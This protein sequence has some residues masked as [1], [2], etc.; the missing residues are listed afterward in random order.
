MVAPAEKVREDYEIVKGIVTAN[1]G[2][3][4]RVR[5]EDGRTAIFTVKG[6]ASAIG[7]GTDVGVVAHR[8]TEKAVF[9]VDRASGQRFNTSMWHNHEAKSPSP[10]HGF[11]RIF[12]MLMLL[13][14]ILGQLVMLSGF[15]GTLFGTVVV[16][17]SMKGHVTTSLPRLF[18]ATGAYFFGSFIFFKG[19]I[20]GDAGDKIL[21]FLILAVAAAA[22]S[23]WVSRP[24]TAFYAEVAKLADEAAA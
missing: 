17:S 8:G 6:A 4:M 19:W 22:Y 9:V 12:S 24:A 13:V 5:M 10:L 11:V 7:V 23:F 18:A 20:G 2:D 3:V 21:G 16:A 14:P 15:L 1:Q